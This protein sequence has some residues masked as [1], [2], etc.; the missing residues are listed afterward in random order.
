MAIRKRASAASSEAV[1]VAADFLPR[2]GCLVEQGIEWL[3]KKQDCPLAEVSKQE[4]R[5]RSMVSCLC[6]QMEVLIDS[7]EM[8][9][10]ANWCIR[11]LVKGSQLREDLRDSLLPVFELM[12]APPVVLCS[13]SELWQQTK[14]LFAMGQTAR[15]QF[16][17][18]SWQRSN[19]LPGRFRKPLR[20]CLTVRGSL[21][22]ARCL[23]PAATWLPCS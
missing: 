22:H 3:L 4:Q 9:A 8:E 12:L 5:L 16:A 14:A 20:S 17:Q 21:W 23:E 18:S 11:C 1:A 10:C 6:C 13:A 7:G 15:Q 19:L 2:L